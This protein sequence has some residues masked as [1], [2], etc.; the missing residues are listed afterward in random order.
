MTPWGFYF[1]HYTITEQL[2]N[3]NIKDECLIENPMIQGHVHHLPTSANVVAR[4]QYKITS[5]FNN[6]TSNQ[7]PNLNADR[8]MFID[9]N[10]TMR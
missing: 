2:I 1:A 6:I 3:I 9:Q 7:T 8:I 5:L 10:S 4:I